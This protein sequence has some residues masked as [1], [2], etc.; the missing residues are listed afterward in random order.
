MQN[1]QKKRKNKQKLWPIQWKK[2][3]KKLT[4][5]AETSNFLEKEFKLSFISILIKINHGQRT[6]EAKR[7]MF[8][9]K[10]SIKTEKV[11]KK[12]SNRNLGAAKYHRWSRNF[13]RGVN[14][15]N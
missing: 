1:K 7:T 15:Q 13:T 4:E 3:K 14:R 2:K 10:D 5:R 12:V 11:Y 9:E 6:M 8:P